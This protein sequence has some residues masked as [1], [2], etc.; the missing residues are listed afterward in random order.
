MGIIVK[1]RMIRN[2]A[3]TVLWVAI[4][5]LL[6]GDTGAE[7]FL[8][9][10][11]GQNELLRIKVHQLILEP[12]RNIPVLI[13]SDPPEKRGLLIWIGF[14][15]A[16]AISSEMHGIKHRR[17]LTHDLLER[18]ISKTQL[19]IQRVV[20]THFKEGTYYATI[21]VKSGGQLM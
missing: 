19:K 2:P 17:P 13:L 5:V 18:F 11:S 21:L 7:A 20:I 4:L 9:V 1:N 14:P 3:N 8:S 12:G 6:S 15:E 10:S 16:N